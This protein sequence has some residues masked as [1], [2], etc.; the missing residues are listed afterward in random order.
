M[1]KEIIITTLKI[2]PS[3]TE[4][5]GLFASFFLTLSV[6][7]LAS[8]V[9]RCHLVPS[10]PLPDVWLSVTV[11]RLEKAKISLHVIQAAP[12]RY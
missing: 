1:S 4:L 5:V 8:T 3:L 10:G 11:R 2:K 12:P 6:I 7:L 9:E